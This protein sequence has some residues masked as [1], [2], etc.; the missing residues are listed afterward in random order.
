M[1]PTVL[2]FTGGGLSRGVRFLVLPTSIASG[3]IVQTVVVCKAPGQIAVHNLYHRAA[4]VV[5]SPVTTK[6][7]AI[8]FDTDLA[9]LLKAVM[10]PYAQ[11]Y[12]VQSRVFFP[13]NN[14]RWYPSTSLTGNGGATGN[15]QATQTTG[16][17]ALIGSV[18][19]QAGIGRWYLP[20]PSV[21]DDDTSASPGT[22]YLTNAA[23]LGDWAVAQQTVAASGGGGSVILQPVLIDRQTKVTNDIQTYAV[24]DAWATQK[25]RGA[26]GKL[27]K[28]P[29]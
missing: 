5:G 1:A 21:A 16:L 10:A 22:T 20:F 27:N 12:G 29:F 23:L 7:V 15:P 19:G 28:L 11:Y 25:R 9:P 13:I 6:E 8:A 24:R 18:W 26:F 17:L 14:E 4:V 2:G 3:N